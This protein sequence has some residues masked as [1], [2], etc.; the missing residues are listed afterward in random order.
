MRTAP[1]RSTAARTSAPLHLCTPLH[2]EHTRGYIT[3][4]AA[5]LTQKHIKFTTSETIFEIIKK[6]TRL[7][8]S[9]GYLMAFKWCCTAV[10]KAPPSSWAISR[11]CSCRTKARRPQRALPVRC[12]TRSGSGVPRRVSARA[13]GGCK[14]RMQACAHLRR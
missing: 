4:Y 13:R 5:T 12:N 10:L 1:M 14:W 2:L 6:L 9:H 7:Q 3:P 11:S 8:Y